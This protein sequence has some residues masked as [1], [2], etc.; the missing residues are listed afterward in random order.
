MELLRPS[1]AA[2][3]LGISVIHLRKLLRTGEI[4]GFRLSSSPVGRWRIPEEEIENFIES[5]Q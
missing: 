1:E 4:N 5:K 2:K 3:K